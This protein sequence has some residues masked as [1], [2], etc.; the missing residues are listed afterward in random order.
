MQ[1]LTPS[2]D[3]LL[4]DRV[5]P[6]NWNRGKCMSFYVGNTFLPSNYELSFSVG[7]PVRNLTVIPL[8]QSAEIS[9]EAQYPPFGDIKEYRVT[10]AGEGAVFLSLRYP[11]DVTL[12]QRVANLQS[13]VQYTLSVVTV[14]KAEGGCA[15]S[16]GLST[17]VMVAFKIPQEV[18]M[19]V[20]KAAL[21]VFSLNK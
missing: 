15:G 7:R 2:V 9:W 13:G 6:G 5:R 19:L 12:P 8:D 14:N 3:R 1:E 20:K 17:P 4:L 21:G 16:G 18:F 10:L 11:A